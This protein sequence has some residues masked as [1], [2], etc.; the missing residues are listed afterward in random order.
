MTKRHDYRGQVITRDG[1][2]WVIAARAWG[3]H[4]GETYRFKTLGKA[5]D[6]IDRM[7]DGGE[8]R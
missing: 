5:K 6:F 3:D 8:W 7:I 4:P 1:F 2:R